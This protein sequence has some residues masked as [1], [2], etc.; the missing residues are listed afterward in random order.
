MFHAN[1]PQFAP[2]YEAPC[3]SDDHPLTDSNDG[4]EHDHHVSAEQVGRQTTQRSDQ[5]SGGHIDI[6]IVGTMCQT[7]NISVSYIYCKYFVQLLLY[8]FVD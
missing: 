3:D 8:D 6:N 5:P 2:P 1:L 4:E 7:K